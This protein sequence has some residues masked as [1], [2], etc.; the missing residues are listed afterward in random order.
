MRL[1]RPTTIRTNIPAEYP[2]PPVNNDPEA[3][4]ALVW[5]LG[6][7]NKEKLRAVY[8]LRASARDRD[9][10]GRMTGAIPLFLKV[11]RQ[12]SITGPGGIK[13]IFIHYVC[14]RTTDSAAEGSL[15]LDE[16][17]YN[18]VEL[19]TYKEESSAP[20][21]AIAFTVSNRTF[22]ERVS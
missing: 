21:M 20:I 8:A 10:V 14:I 17:E 11:C 12:R 16:S 22:N 6:K 1:E 19:E 3:Y 4:Y 15:L 7:R 5:P 2:P 9:W 18:P 13:R